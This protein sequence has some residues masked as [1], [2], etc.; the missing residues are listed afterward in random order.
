MESELKV[1]DMIPSFQAKDHEGFNVTEEDIIG[2]TAVIY[3]YPQNETPGC[4]KEACSFRDKMKDLDALATLVIGVSPDSVESHKNFIKNHHLEYS[5][6]SDER[7]KMCRQFGIL[8]GDKVVRSTFLIDSEG[9]IKWI[10]KPTN[11]DGHV[12]RVIAA[13]KEHCASSV[14]KFDDFNTD[15]AEFLQGGFKLQ[16]TENEIKEN[17][18]TKFHLKDSDISDKKKRTRKST[19]P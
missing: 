16:E 5:L 14:I 4:T 19:E 8:E 13:I 11:I 6:L 18:K 10:E 12:D 3:F 17:I 2:I 15:Y 7:K 1:G 9:I